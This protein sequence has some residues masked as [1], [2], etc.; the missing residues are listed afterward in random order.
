MPAPELY[1]F[2]PGQTAWKVV[3]GLARII[4]G[5]SKLQVVSHITIRC[6]VYYSCNCPFIVASIERQTFGL[7]LETGEHQAPEI[8]YPLEPSLTGSP[9]SFKERQEWQRQ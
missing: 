1:P 3:N 5:K 8:E 9:L 6:E 7:S 4:T 2:H